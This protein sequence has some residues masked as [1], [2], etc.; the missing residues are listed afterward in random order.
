MTLAP[1]S[2]PAM[3]EYLD[4][5]PAVDVSESEYRRLLGYPG[6]HAPGERAIELMAWA[7]AVY[8][9]CGRPFIYMRQAELG[10]A[11]ETLRLDGHEFRSARLG[12]LLSGAGASRVML[13][14]VGAGGACEERASLLWTEARPDEYFFLEVFGSAV[15]EHLVSQANARI[16][17][18]A[19][20][21]GQVALPHYSP[22][23]T[24]WDVAD[25]NTLFEIVTR[26]MSGPLPEPLGVLPSGMLRPKKSLLAVVG[27]APRRGSP[28]RSPQPTP[29]QSCSF[30]PCQYRRA[31]HLHSPGPVTEPGA[32][33]ARAAPEDADSPLTRGASYSLNEGALR[34]WAG[35]RV[36]ISRCEDGSVEARFRFDGTTCSNLGRPISLDYTVVLGPPSDGYPI[37]ATACRPAT[38]DTG[39]ASMCAY[40]SDAGT[41]MDAVRAERPLAGRPLNDVLAW[42]PPVSPSGCLCDASS[43]THK[44][45][46]ALEAIHYTLANAGAGTPAARA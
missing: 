18:L 34:K 43:R 42:A 41:L 17:A 28:T 35:E 6:G 38:G 45:V 37:R 2:V 25:Q 15:V 12:G 24:G 30:S 16:C 9:E 3:P 14:A 1:E 33:E 40:L 27:L 39:L 20:G 5:R 44:W 19:E 32:R 26:G 7:R 36:H 29:C 23:Y 13:V 21:A 22:G 46:L 4:D 10:G 8:A 11:G 31:P